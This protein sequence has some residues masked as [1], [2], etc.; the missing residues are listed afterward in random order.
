MS[1]ADSVGELIWESTRLPPSNSTF[2]SYD[3][4]P[5]ISQEGDVVTFSVS[6]GQF[7]NGVPRNVTVSSTPTNLLAAKFSSRL[8][9]GVRS[10]IN[11]RFLVYAV[12]FQ[13]TYFTAEFEEYKF[14]NVPD[15]ADDPG[16][17]LGEI[18]VLGIPEP[19]AGSLCLLAAWSVVLRGPRRHHFHT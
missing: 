16:A 11:G 12:A 19:G 6:N 2:P 5:Q 13:T 17:L 10:P 14:A 3:G 7:E 18:N 15:G 8:V 1:L 9:G 4:I